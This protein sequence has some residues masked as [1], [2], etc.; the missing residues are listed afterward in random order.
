MKF[1]RFINKNLNSK[2]KPVFLETSGA[3]ILDPAGNLLGYLGA[4]SNVTQR[5]LNEEKLRK[6]SLAV[7]Q[8]PVSIVI[9]NTRGDIEY[10]N[11]R[12]IELSGYSWDE[13]LGN[14]PRVLKSGKTSPSEY[15]NL[16]DTI[17]SGKEWKGE[18]FNRKKNGDYF[19]ESSSISPI[20]D[21]SGRITHYLGIK[22]DITEKK[23]A[24]KNMIDKIIATEERERLRY[25]NELHDGLG[26]IISTIKLY[27]QLLNES[28]DA[29]QRKL[30]I[31][32][33]DTCIDEAI[34]SLK[35]ISH[36]LSPNVV[37]NFGLVT[38][39]QSFINR[40]KD[41]D[42]LQITFNSD[43][44]GR[45]DRN[46]EITLYRIITEMINNTYKYAEATAI[47]IELKYSPQDSTVTLN[48]KDNGKGFD[49]EKAI[50]KGRGIGISNIYQRVNAMNGRLSLRSSPGKGVLLNVALNSSLR[51]IS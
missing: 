27:F 38:G 30:I 32:K 2:G 28:S 6:L 18:F 43:I 23:E 17:S 46:V 50:Q 4:D 40:L 37:N 5:L 45:L 19:W 41:T 25:S 49:V 44:E 21:S 36:N 35:E 20:L 3:P 33:A 24:A 14:N 7:E 1:D 47:I 29:M 16:W 51:D 34:Q 42:V 9:T 13:L 31:E 22:E 39:I 48:Y 12:F 8:S 26:P 10:V 15:K 11:R